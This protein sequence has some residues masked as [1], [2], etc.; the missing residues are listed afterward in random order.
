[1]MNQIKKNTN[2]VVLKSGSLNTNFPLTMI[3]ATLIATLSACGGGSNSNT[4]VY[5]PPPTPDPVAKTFQL[6]Q[7]T[8][9]NSKI[10]PLLS[11]NPGGP[12]GSSN[13][14]LRGGDILV[15]DANDNIIIGGLGVDVLMGYDGD[16]IMIGGTE[17]FN[18]NVDGDEKGADNRD[19]SFGHNGDDA[20][21]WSPGDGSDYV[22]GGDGIDV[23]IF[24]VLG[25]A[26]DDS[27]ST[28]GAPFFSV[29]PPSTAGSQ[30]F[31]GVFLDENNQPTVRV[32]ESP[33]FCTVLDA[34]AN[35]S[36]Y[37]QLKIDNIV[38]F[39]IRSIADQF[40]AGTK[41]DDDGLRV[42]LTLKNTEYVVCTKRELDASNSENNIEVLDIS[43][44]TPVVAALAD[45]PEHI[46]AIIQ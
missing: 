29:N 39:S 46:Q 13:Q 2:T 31:D 37:Q 5:T 41:T 28:E 11:A 9:K 22:D 19:R 24:G 36:S 43:G 21:I 27:G 10:H 45:L 33:G 7:G 40:D 16:D 4:D 6:L 38:Q 14:S 42:S 35:E 18:S 23:L 3:T 26:K 17:D 15:G 1:M 30:D 20:V 44:P 12:G 25:E 34:V 8:D 32:S